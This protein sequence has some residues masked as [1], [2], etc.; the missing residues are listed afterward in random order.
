MSVLLLGAAAVTARQATDPQSGA[1]GV[2][3]VPAVLPGTV[4]PAPE[5]PPDVLWTKQ[6]AAAPARS[7]IL[8]GQHIVVAYLPGVIVVHR[9]SDGEQVWKTDLNPEQRLAADETM[10]FVAS[11]EAVHALRLTDGAPAWRAPTGTLTAPL[12][13]AGGW[14]IAANATKLIALRAADGTAVWTIDAPAQREGAAIS[15]ETLFVPSNDGY[16]RARSLKSGTAIWEQRL[17]GQPGEP[18][19]IGNDVLVSG[20][21]KALYKLSVASGHVSWRNRVGASIRGPAATDGERVFIAALDNMIRAYDLGDGE[22]KWQVGL[23]FRP[24]TGPVVAGGTVFITSPGTDIKML[25]ALNGTQAGNIS[26]PAKLAITPD[27]RES[28]FGVAIAAVTGG[29][30]ESWNLLITRPVRALPVTAARPTK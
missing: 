21:D 11:G 20:T 13:V 3:G 28:E 10:L 22:L 8:A 19:V 26:F 17:G 24:L 2:Q 1:E 14:V 30:E 6:I 23:P 15:G 16:V 12:L 9:A 5:A 4:L 7:P 18:V 25:R 29:L 27:M